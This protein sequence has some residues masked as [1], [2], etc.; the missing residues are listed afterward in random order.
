MADG[1]DAAPI[2]VSGALR[3]GLT[4]T[5]GRLDLHP[6]IT[7]GPDAGAVSLALG[8][9]D[10]ERSLGDL[11][12]RYFN[13]PPDQVR[14]NFAAAIGAILSARGRQAGKTRVGEKS[15][16]TIGVFPTLGALFPKA[17]FV[18]CVRDGRDVAASLLARRWIDPRT[19]AVF[20]Y[21]RSPGAAAAQWT[22][23]ASLGI[24][25]ENALGDRLFRLRYEDLVGDQGETAARLFDFLE[26]APVA[27]T[28]RVDGARFDLADDERES[29]DELSK[30]I[31]ARFVGRW[32][33]DL[34]PSAIREIMP[35]VAPFLGAF[36]Y[37]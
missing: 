30:P 11:H 4:L 13:L 35:I 8:A 29:A 7:C 19:G 22:M 2:F 27:I 3:S 12:R 6:D 16:A 25:A 28:D 34:S 37:R 17:R 14:A 32:R 36:G 9:R 20:D 26:V 10:F 33:R 5:R 23:A 15:A 21:C 1:A 31:D 18:H 24:A